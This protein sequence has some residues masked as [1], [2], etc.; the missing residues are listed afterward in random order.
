MATGAY[1]SGKKIYQKA[2]AVLD[3][4]PTG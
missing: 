3:S 1:W 4:A 2:E